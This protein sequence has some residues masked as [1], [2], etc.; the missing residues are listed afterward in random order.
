LLPTVMRKKPLLAFEEL[1][2]AHDWCE[3][4][5]GRQQLAADGVDD[6][7]HACAGEAIGER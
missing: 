1:K 5:L 4:L 6:D 3:K 2:R 7:C